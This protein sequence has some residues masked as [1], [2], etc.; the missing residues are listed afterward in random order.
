MASAD[1]ARPA[2]A[3]V[4]R[5][6]DAPGTAPDEAAASA[7]S[8]EERPDGE[9]VRASPK[10]A[11]KRVR[12]SID[13]DDFIKNASAAMRAAQ[14]QVNA[15][16]AQ[17]KNERRKKQRLLKKA[18]TLSPSDLERIAT[19]KRCGFVPDSEFPQP[20]PSGTA[21]ASSSKGSAEPPS[22]IEGGPA[23]AARSAAVMSESPDR[24]D[25]AGESDDA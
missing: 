21:A 22:G 4:G 1:V 17:A 3:Q 15:C 6:A 18:A 7:E 16:K 12:P 8:R 25:D 10:G 11:A 2:E 23:P 24:E 19:L 5:V 13:L 20:P 14:K 9:E